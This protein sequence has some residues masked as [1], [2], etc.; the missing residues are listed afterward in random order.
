MT[1]MPT[2]SPAQSPHQPSGTRAAKGKHHWWRWVAAVVVVLLVV[3]LGASWYFSGQIASGALTSTP[4]G[5]LPA[6][7]DVKVVAVDS[8]SVT[9][10]KGPDAGV[11]FD[12]D[13]VYGLAWDGGTGIVGAA[14]PGPDETVIRP[15]EEI[16]T[17]TAP[18][19]GQLAALDSAYWLAEPSA[20]LGLTPTEVMVDGRFPAW[21]FPADASA[22][23]TT[24]I[25]IAVHGQNGSRSDMLRA[26]DAVHQAGLP[27][28]DIT[29]RNDLGVPA[30][31]TGRLQYGASEW[32]DLDAAVTWARANG[33]DDIVL[34]GQ[35]MGGA[36]VASFL[37]HSDQADVV[38]KVVLDA[39]MLSLGGSV[40][41]AARTSMPVT[42]GAVPPPVIWAAEQLTS[43]RYG[44]DW[45]AVDYLDD[46]SWVSVPTLVLHGTADPRVPVTLSEELA[47]AEPDLVQLVTIPDAL[48]VEAWN[49]DP[50]RWRQEVVEFTSTPTS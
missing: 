7:D 26:V 6:F 40:E 36:I 5:A 43:L 14:T 16:V 25:A 28:L 17:G 20:S 11:N 33:A 44:V 49:F 27:V 9:L 15:L 29:Y 21:L 2:T 50:Q 3:F 34:V 45:A 42:G 23:P 37:E 48:H 35:S 30:D 47:V 38:S 8:D 19:V 13:A 1:V 4:D 24:T 31:P 46:T 39:P 41:Y 12:A 18:V 32:Q 22:A 10:A